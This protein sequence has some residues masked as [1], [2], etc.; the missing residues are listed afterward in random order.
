MSSYSPDCS[1]TTVSAATGNVAV[2]N[3]ATAGD[4]AVADADADAPSESDR[5]DDDARDESPFRADVDEESLNAE[6]DVDD[7]GR[8]EDEVDM[9]ETRRTM[10]VG[11][12]G[13]LAILAGVAKLPD[14]DDEDI[15]TVLDTLVEGKPS[16][17]AGL[18][19]ARS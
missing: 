19:G 16:R 4:D 14:D 3:S 11:V 5:A 12:M 2:A 10:T 8:D 7:E 18:V 13:A 17:Q 9:E 1:D 15:D 6:D